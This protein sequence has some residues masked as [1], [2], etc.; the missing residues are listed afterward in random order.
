[1]TK[2]TSELLKEIMSSALLQEIGKRLINEIGG[3]SRYHKDKSPKGNSVILSINGVKKM[4]IV[5][6]SETLLLTVCPCSI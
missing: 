2:N 1:M 3:E 6:M 4:L 5:N